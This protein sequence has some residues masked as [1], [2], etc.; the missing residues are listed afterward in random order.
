V[1]LLA[2]VIAA[3]WAAGRW[4]VCHGEGCS[5]ESVDMRILQWLHAHRSAWLD[6]VMV[7]ATWLGSLHVLLPL[8]LLWLACR[9]VTLIDRLL[10]PLAL[11][12]AAVSAHVIKPL[13]ARPRPALHEAL[14]ALPEDLS[15]PSAH[16]AQSVAFWF[17]LCLGANAYLSHGLRLPLIAVAA[18]VVLAVCA[19]RM[20]LQ[21]HYPTDVAAGFMIGSAWLFATRHLLRRPARTPGH[22]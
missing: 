6:R 20:H 17:A 11:I 15:F 5:A 14:T 9:R 8:A 7:A 1:L 16:A 19:S 10:A 22:A 13:A 2:I 18:I 21:V 3:A 12:G 4:W